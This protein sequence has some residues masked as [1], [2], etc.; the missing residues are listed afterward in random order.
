MD[1]ILSLWSPL[2]SDYIYLNSHRVLQK[3]CWIWSFFCPQ[4]VMAPSLSQN[5]GLSLGVRNLPACGPCSDTEVMSQAPWWM[6]V[7]WNPRNQRLN[8]TLES[9]PP[10]S[11]PLDFTSQGH[12][13][14][15]TNATGHPPTSLTDVIPQCASGISTHSTHPAA[16]AHSPPYSMPH[17]PFLQRPSAILSTLLNEL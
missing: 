13:G 14:N 15:D 17:S 3:I 6:K 1:L 2:F 11:P 7:L 12:F 16:W 4:F 8:G 10:T 5:R 9:I